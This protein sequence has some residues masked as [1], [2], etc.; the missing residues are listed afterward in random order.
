MKFFFPLLHFFAKVFKKDIYNN[1]IGGNL[2]LFVAKYKKFKK[3][4]LSFKISFVENRSLVDRL[5]N[6]GIDNCIYL[7][8]FKT[9]KPIE[10]IG[11]NYSRPFKLC[12]FSRVMKEKGIEDAIKV[13][14]LINNNEKGLCSLD[15][16]GQIDP[17]EREYFDSLF[18]SMPDFI[19]YKGV[20]DFN[21]TSKVLKDYYLL[22]FPTKFYGEGIPGTIIDGFFAGV[23]IVASKWVNYGDI[24]IEG[25]NSYLFEFGSLE[26]FYTVLMFA[27]SDDKNHIKLQHNCINS[28]KEFLASN[29]VGTM[30]RIVFDG[31]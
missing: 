20:I 17:E 21:D 23:P 12:T 30:L 7:P 22:L 28:S 3:Y 19:S 2:D 5:S 16:Y 31:N 14:E 4:L 27:M 24:L 29:V 10:L 25:Y 11:D 26:D 13:V 15:I 8:N 6:L 9:M 18:E 1:V